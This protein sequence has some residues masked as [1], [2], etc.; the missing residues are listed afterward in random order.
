MYKVLYDYLNNNNNTMEMKNNF[1]NN[2]AN[3][4]TI[5]DLQTKDKN[6][7]TILYYL[8]NYHYYDS[9]IFLIKTLKLK[10][11]HFQ[12]KGN[13]NYTELYL[14][15]AGVAYNISKIIELINNNS[16]KCFWK[17]EHFQNKSTRRDTELYNLC[18]DKNKEA[19]KLVA[20]LG[21]FQWKLEHCDSDMERKYMKSIGVFKVE[22][23]IEPN[24][25][26][27]IET[28][29]E[30]KVKKESIYQEFEKLVLKVKEINKQKGNVK[31][32]ISL[33]YKQ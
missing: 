6:G 1:I 11:K 17:P 25:E 32:S 33:N 3:G 8:C 13:N 18:Y 16:D 27:K 10:P 22:P 7:S 24:I 31:I 14:L 4:L 15:C 20:K 12:N 23:K 26:P 9:V 2:V 5:K 30:S 21:N 19:I 29:A 28:K